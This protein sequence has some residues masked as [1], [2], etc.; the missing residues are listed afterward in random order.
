MFGILFM[1][2]ETFAD[3]RHHGG[4]R[5]SPYRRNYHTPQYN[6]GPGGMGWGFSLGGGSSLVYIGS[7]SRWVYQN[8]WR[9][10]AWGRWYV[11]SVPVQ[12][13]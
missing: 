9:Q 12:V 1:A 2:V 3:H 4:D 5:C 13:W 7:Q 6:Y 11:V 10:D 8:Q